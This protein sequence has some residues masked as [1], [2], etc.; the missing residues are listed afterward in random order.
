MSTI[1]VT[2]SILFISLVFV[3]CSTTQKIETLK[4]LPSDDAPMVYTSKTSFVNMPL[5]ISLK[6]IEAQ[7]NKTLN[8]EIYNDS[9]LEDDKT[10][11]IITKTAP[12]RLVEKNG[13]EELEE[14]G[15]QLQVVLQGALFK[16]SELTGD[17]VNPSTR[18]K[19]T[20]DYYFCRITKL[21]NSLA[22]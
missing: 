7:L 20:T 21:G 17:F 12:I 1:K 9:N 4:P 19:A 8:G 22:Q 15:Y 6:E 13:K 5:E 10:E 14:R 16:V 18:H 3:G 2:L 11:M